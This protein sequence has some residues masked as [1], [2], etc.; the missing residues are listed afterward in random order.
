MDGNLIDSILFRH[1]TGSQRGVQRPDW[2]DR[3]KLNFVK[4][5]G[6]GTGVNVAAGI[7]R[8][9]TEA[10]RLLEGNTPW[11]TLT[12]LLSPEKFRKRAASARPAADFIYARATSTSAQPARGR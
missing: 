8:L 2:N 10:G 4:R 9:L 1:R 11:S 12:R 3:A 7:E 5:T 6:H